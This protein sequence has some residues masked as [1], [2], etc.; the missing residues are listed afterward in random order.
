[1]IGFELLT[2]ATIL[3]CDK[4]AMPLWLPASRKLI[5]TYNSGFPRALSKVGDLLPLKR[6]TLSIKLV[7]ANV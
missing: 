4:T 3:I 1:M 7:Q 2:I 6:K 5:S